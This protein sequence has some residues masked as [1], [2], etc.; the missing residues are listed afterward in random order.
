MA[1]EPQAAIEE[2][3]LQTIRSVAGG[4]RYSTDNSRRMFDAEPPPVC[5]DV[6]VSVW[7]DLNRTSEMDT[8]LN[9]VFGVN[10][11]ITLRN[12]LPWDRQVELRDELEARANQIRAAVHVDCLMNSIQRQASALMGADGTGQRVGF[13]DRLMFQRLEGLQKV[14][15]DWFKAELDR[16]TAADAGLAL[17]LRFHGLRLIQ[18]LLTM[19]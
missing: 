6:F 19:E 3:V 4:R 16:A 2:A 13:R 17:T 5:G 7:H 14:G 8:C 12:R 11:T 9:E 15:P 10:V 1:M 18:A